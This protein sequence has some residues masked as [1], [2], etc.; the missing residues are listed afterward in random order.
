MPKPSYLLGTLYVIGCDAFSE[1]NAYIFSRLKDK[2]SG[3]I[4]S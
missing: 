2:R 3:K 4:E 1:K